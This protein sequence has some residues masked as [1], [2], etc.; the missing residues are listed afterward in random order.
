LIYFTPENNTWK[1]D[2]DDEDETAALIKGMVNEVR[3]ISP[4]V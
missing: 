1:Y 4:S 3:N 2:D